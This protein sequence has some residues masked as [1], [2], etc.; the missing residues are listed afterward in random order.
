MFTLE[1]GLGRCKLNAHWT[2][3]PL[4]VDWNRIRAEFIVYSSNN[5]K[6]THSYA[7]TNSN[8]VEAFKSRP[9]YT[10][11]IRRLRYELQWP[12]MLGRYWLD[13]A[14]K[15]PLT[16]WSH[17]VCWSSRSMSST[18]SYKVREVIGQTLVCVSIHLECWLNKARVEIVTWAAV[19]VANQQQF[20][21]NSVSKFW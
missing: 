13:A 20:G 11:S 15:R 3:P 6:I 10:H 1:F 16:K 12:V 9:P 5:N 17:V 21:Y 7:P 19:G 2:N 8:I 4:E 14:K 18:T